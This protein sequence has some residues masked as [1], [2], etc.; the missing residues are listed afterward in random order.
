MVVGTVTEIGKSAINQ[1]DPIVIL[2][3]EQAT[4]ELRTVS[5]IQDFNESDQER[6]DLEKG[7]KISFDGR[8]YTILEVGSLANENLKTI[9]HATLNFSSVPKE[10]KLANGIYLEPFDLPKF[11]VGTKIDYIK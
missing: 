11:K 1:K 9:G 4:E 8:A 10:D 3:G 2:F 7:D 6:I 5:V